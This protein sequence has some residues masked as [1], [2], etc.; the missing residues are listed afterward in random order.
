MKI[1]IFGV[2][3]VGLVTGTCL[4][5]LGHEVL[6]VDIDTNKIYQLQQGICPIYELGLETILHRNMQAHRLQFTTD[7][8]QAVMHGECI[9]IAVG[10]PQLADGKANLHY[11]FDAAQAI[12]RYM[13]EFKVVVV[14]STVPV[15]TSQQVQEHI[16]AMLRLQD[17]EQTFAMVSNPEFLKE[18]TAI[19]DFMQPDRIVI[20]CNEERAQRYLTE[21]YAPF[22]DKLLFMDITSAEL[23]KYAA[24]A[25]LAT[26]ISFMNELSHIAEKVGADIEIVR[27]AIGRDPRIG[28][29]FLRAGCGYGGSCF[30]KD[31]RALVQTAQQLEI[32]MPLLSAVEQ[33]NQ[34]QKQ[35]LVNKLLA[36]FGHT[37]TQQVIAIWGLAF[38]PHTDDIREASSR[39]LIEALWKIGVTEI[40]AYDPVA[41][42][43]FQQTYGERNDL[44]YMSDPYAAVE[45]ADA[46]VIV[47]EWPEFMQ[48]NW[49]RVVNS[50]RQRIIV[51]GRN[52]CNLSLMQQ[53][54][55]IYYSI[56]R[57]PLNQEPTVLW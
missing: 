52:I 43:A 6:C 38:K 25:M 33:V 54:S 16:K 30:P 39:V 47:T 24:N 4:A 42:P 22:V 37:L 36:H 45:A 12:G 1:S 49:P 34:Q 11:V 8:M 46:L 3:Y 48:I 40:R 55:V 41:M 10:T 53:L 23:S 13:T 21:V 19:Q 5:E 31:V 26:R 35:I 57:A 50:M 32:D 51:D 20:G 56:G 14:K 17:N 15:G 29:Y 7:V 28:A 18:G 2:G 9:F 27:E 44:Y